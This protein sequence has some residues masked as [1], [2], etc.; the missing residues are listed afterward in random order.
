[1]EHRDDSPI[2]LDVPESLRDRYHNPLRV[3]S[4]IRLHTVHTAFL[5]PTNI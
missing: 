2:R 5:P 4:R 3:M 1:M